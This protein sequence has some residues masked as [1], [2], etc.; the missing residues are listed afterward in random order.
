ML[1]TYF[2][3]IEYPKTSSIEQPA[4]DHDWAGPLS[5]FFDALAIRSQI[6][7]MRNDEAGCIGQTRSDGR[8]GVL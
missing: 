3:A 1:A 7:Q 5:H 4:Q 8:N 6:I 2:V